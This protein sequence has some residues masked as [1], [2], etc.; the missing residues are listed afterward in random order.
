LQAARHELN[1][2]YSVLDDER[3]AAG[4]PA[5][6]RQRVLRAEQEIDDLESRLATT[7]AAGST[8]AFFARPVEAREIAN[9]LEHDE[10][11]IEY[12]IA[13]DEIMAFIVR[14][15]RDIAAIR[16]IGSLAAVTQLMQSLQFQTA[17][18]LRPGALEGGRGERLVRDAH[19]VLGELAAHTLLAA[20]DSIREA[21]HLIIVPHGVLH[22][23]PFQAMPLDGEPLIEHRSLSYAASARMLAAVRDGA[24]DEGEEAMLSRPMVVGVADE[25][26]PEIEREGREVARQLQCD[27]NGVFF[28]V[29]A[30]AE[31]ISVA[32]PHATLLHMACHGRYSPESPLGSG[33][34]LADRWLTARD[35][36]AMQLRAQLV[37]LSGCET[38]VN[39]VKAG[40]E[41]LG[42]LRGF[43]IAG[44]PR[45]L[46]SLWR[47]HDSTTREF[48]AA[49]YRCLNTL[50]ARSRPVARA[51]R[52]AQLHMLHAHPHPALW[53]SFVLAGKP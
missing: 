40:D 30:T 49:F 44:A 36:L 26:A 50:D 23:L 52:Q 42:L 47:V 34:R 45:V 25:H 11:L 46:A 12:F 1:G 19:A 5:R 41:L 13:G 20:A 31:K 8:A 10:A 33:L 2:L 18:A 51:L 48:M 39:L 43:F 9:M 27:Q 22:M 29:E 16:R 6:W 24:A 53:A 17:R 37:T 35:L 21:A 14:R 32:L 4:G 3:G 15:D 38:G 28:G 7:D